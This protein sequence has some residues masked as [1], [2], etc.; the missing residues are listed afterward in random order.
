M[1]SFSWKGETTRNLICG[2]IADDTLPRIDRTYELPIA[3]IY[4]AK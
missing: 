2:V 3:P 4:T 1:G